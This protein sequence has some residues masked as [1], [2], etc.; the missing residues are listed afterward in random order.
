MRVDLPSSTLPAVMKRKSG[1]VVAVMVLSLILGLHVT[2]MRS[3]EN[4]K[5]CL[6][7][8]KDDFVIFGRFLS[9]GVGFPRLPENPL[10]GKIPYSNMGTAS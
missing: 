10:K 5:E 4:G 3:S 9:G 2:L 1:A 8:K 7:L 6:V